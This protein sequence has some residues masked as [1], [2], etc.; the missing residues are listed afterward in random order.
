MSQE[1]IDVVH[2]LYE[3]FERA[4]IDAVLAAHDEDVELSD[5][6]P[7]GRGDFGGH[8]ALREQFQSFLQA[9]LSVTATVLTERDKRVVVREVWS[10]QAPDE[11]GGGKFEL[12]A[13]LV[14]GFAAGRIVRVEILETEAEALE[15]VGL[16]E[17]D[18]KPAD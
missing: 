6:R 1:N 14:F 8:A 15:A 18:L 4:D 16:R 5:R 2:R 3:D 7:F 13:Y 11:A 12:V 17:E 9:D 10:G